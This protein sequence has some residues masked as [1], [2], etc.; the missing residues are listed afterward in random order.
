MAATKRTV[1]NT[2]MV[3]TD[4]TTVYHSAS[5]AMEKFCTILR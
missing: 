1:F 5:E 4:D 2:D 3:I